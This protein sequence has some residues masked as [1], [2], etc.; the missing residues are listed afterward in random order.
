MVSWTLSKRAWSVA[1]QNCKKLA[2]IS[3]SFSFSLTLL[4]AEAVKARGVCG[5]SPAVVLRFSGFGRDAF[6]PRDFPLELLCVGSSPIEGG[7]G[8]NILGYVSGK[9]REAS[10]GRADGTV[11]MSCRA[12]RIP[13]HA[14][15]R[16]S[17]APL[18]ARSCVV[19]VESTG[20]NC[21]F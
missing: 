21:N 6:E 19:P 1:H 16:W 20:R 10:L 5:E 17:C 12:H 14:C 18:G 11:A 3:F 15:P 4:S 13:K 8:E 7:E 2:A 9:E